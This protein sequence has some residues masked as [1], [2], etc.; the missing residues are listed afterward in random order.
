MSEIYLAA[1]FTKFYN[2]TRLS[3]EVLPYENS[4]K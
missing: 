1:F 3:R 2:E 4:W